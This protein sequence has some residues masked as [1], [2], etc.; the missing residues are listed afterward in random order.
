MRLNYF[1]QGNSAN[2]VEI[3]GGRIQTGTQANTDMDGEIA[4]SAGTQAVYNL[5]VTT[6][7]IRNVLSHRNLISEQI[8][9]GYRMREYR[10][11]PYIRQVPSR[12]H[13]LMFA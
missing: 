1:G 5:V 11:L 3:P 6:W 9:S 13:F 2:N 8:A 7:F 4:L 10:L 12:D